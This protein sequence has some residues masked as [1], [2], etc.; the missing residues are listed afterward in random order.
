M[1][2]AGRVEEPGLVPVVERLCASVD[3]VVS[4]H[5]AIEHPSTASPAGATAPTA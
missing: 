3:G 4:V 1:T 2:L 5:Q